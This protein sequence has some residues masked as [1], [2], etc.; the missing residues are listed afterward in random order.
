[1]LQKHFKNFKG[2]LAVLV[3]LLTAATVMLSQTGGVRR[4]EYGGMLEGVTTTVIFCGQ[5]ANA[6]T[7]YM[8]P[9]TG[10][11][12]GAVY[13]DG[14]TANDLSY[15]IGGTGCD[16]ED[17][18]TEATADEVLFANNAIRVMGM[19]CTVSSSGSNGV[20]LNLRDDAAN[21]VP[22]ITITIPTTATTGA[23]GA[24]TTANIAAGST[25][26]LRVIN[27]EDLSAQDAWCQALIQVIP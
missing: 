9:V 24:F 19:V 23:T 20:V 1:M 27:T 11:A 10:F 4:G 13:A 7:I 6:G 8:S 26:A 2:V 16:A 12:S 22:N 17:S 25:M 5:Q 3:A 14:L 15:I 21:L 18:G